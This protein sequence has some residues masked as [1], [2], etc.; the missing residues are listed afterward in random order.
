MYLSSYSQ[1]SVT[2]TTLTQRVLC[3]VAVTDTFPRSAV[4]LVGLGVTLIFIVMLVC[5]LFMLGTVLL[6]IIAEQT[7]AGVRTRTLWF[8]GQLFNL[9]GAK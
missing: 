6:T 2:L 4:A 9:L 5:F 8:V 3:N 1:L 7:A